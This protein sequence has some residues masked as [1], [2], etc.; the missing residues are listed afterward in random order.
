MSCC[1]YIN[2]ETKKLS[3]EIL[4]IVRGVI[5]PLKISK[6]PTIKPVRDRNRNIIIRPLIVQS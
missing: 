3:R 2:Q 4:L 5:I 1:I 6:R